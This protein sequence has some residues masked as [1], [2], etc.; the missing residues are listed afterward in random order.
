MRG[1]VRTQEKCPRCG[2]VFAP[3]KHPL[4][5]DTIDLMCHTCLT[6][7]KHYF[8]DARWIG[9]RGGKVGRLFCDREGRAFDSF[10]IAYRTLEA[11]RKE[12][13]DG[14]FD[15]SKWNPDAMK[16][17]TVE[18]EGERWVETLYRDRSR[19]YAVHQRC[20]FEV[21]V[22]PYMGTMDVRDVR[23]VHVEGFYRK[24]QEKNLQPKSIQSVLYALRTM[25]NRLVKL[26]VLVR[27]PSFPEVMIPKKDR[28]WIDRELQ[29]KVLE[30]IPER[31]K[32][33][34]EVLFETGCRP[35][36]ACALR[37]KSLVDGGIF[38]DRAVDGLTGKLKQTKT[39]IESHKVLSEGLYDRLVALSRDRLPEA[40]LFTTKAGTPY[41]TC[42]LSKPWRHA[43]RAAG[44]VIPFY[45]SV[46]HSR[47]MQALDADKEDRKRRVRGILAHANDTKTAEKSYI[48]DARNRLKSG[49]DG[50]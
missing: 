21:H 8:I 15:S 1:R 16:E 7:P 12:K 42:Y 23:S 45:V 22:V 35:Q 34:Y 47:V 31:L 6:R 39:G 25:L 13:D 44:V 27:C 4:T 5:Q 50:Q 41:R 17:R 2:G 36:E 24:L 14:I 11:I 40:Y 9:D 37:R 46:R 29:D 18:K 38:V 43:T 49:G 30:H 19:T 20:F 33:I 32:I 3:V 48:L 28:G 26:E 10:M